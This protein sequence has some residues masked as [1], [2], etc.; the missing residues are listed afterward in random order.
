MNAETVKNLSET[1]M[2][3]VGLLAAGL[4]TAA[5]PFVVASIASWLR[6]RS[7]ELSQRLNNEQLQMVQTVAELVVRAAEQ[8]GNNGVLVSGSEKKKFA[9]DMARGYFRNLGVK[10]DAAS[11]A[12]LIES[13][14]MRQFRNSAG[15]ADSAQVRSDLLARAVHTAVLA[16]EQSGLKRRALEAGLNLAEEK[17][18]YAVN[19]AT[20]YLAQHGIRVPPDLIDGM[21]EAQLMRFRIEA[22]QSPQ[23]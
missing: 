7:K 16:A 20:D 2:S 5:L 18:T 22:A 3:F 23:G 9:M 19:L 10:M 6:T 8:N 12:G 15:S 17:K 13:E 1:V 21:I 11:I 14:V 4:L